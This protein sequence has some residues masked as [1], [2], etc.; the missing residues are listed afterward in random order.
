MALQVFYSGWSRIVDWKDHLLA[1]KKHKKLIA[2]SE[3]L[4][5]EDVE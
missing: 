3:E 5:D 1:V 2:R 4:H